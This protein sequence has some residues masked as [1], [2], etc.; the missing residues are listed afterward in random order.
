[1]SAFDATINVGQV[2][3]HLN[4]ENDEEK[5]ESGQLILLMHGVIPVGPGQLAP[6]PFGSLRVPV[7]KQFVDELIKDLQEA[8]EQLKEPSK[9]D[10]VNDIEAAERLA[11]F[12]DD[13]KG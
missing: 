8:S 12:N 3:I 2:L 4:R 11:Q 10:I 5:A 9:I 1:M 13:L 7:D 6:I